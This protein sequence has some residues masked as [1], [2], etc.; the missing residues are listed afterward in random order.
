VFDKLKTPRNIFFRIKIKKEDTEIRGQA[1]FGTYFDVLTHR[2]WCSVLSGVTPMDV[3]K[4][5]AHYRMKIN[6]QYVEKEQLKKEVINPWNRNDWGIIK[7]ALFDREFSQLELLTKFCFFL[8]RPLR[9][10]TKLVPKVLG[11]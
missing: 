3:W 10:V 4:S 1:G 11:N 6:R 8:K 2:P 9:Q 5:S 7:E